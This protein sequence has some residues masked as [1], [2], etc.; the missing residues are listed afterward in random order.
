MVIVVSGVL[1]S[2]VKLAISNKIVRGFM[3]RIIA[4]SV[5]TSVHAQGE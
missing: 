2:S 3:L 5:L 1:P 4:R